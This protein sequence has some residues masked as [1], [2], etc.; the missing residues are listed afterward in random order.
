MTPEGFFIALVVVVLINFIGTALLWRHIDR[1]VAEDRSLAQRVSHLESTVSAL[2]TERH[3]SEIREGIAA[4]RERHAI[5]ASA[6]E[7]IQTHLLER[8]RHE[9]IRRTTA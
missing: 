4:I 9:A 1:C 7:T 5:T 8:E 2:P 3:L 6:L